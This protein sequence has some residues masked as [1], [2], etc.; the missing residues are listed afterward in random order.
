MAATVK[1]AILTE[2]PR[3]AMEMVMGMVTV[4]IGVVIMTMT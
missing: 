4:T 2:L 3:K 1:V